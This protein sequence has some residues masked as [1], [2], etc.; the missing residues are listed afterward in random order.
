MHLEERLPPELVDSLWQSWVPAAHLPYPYQRDAFLF[1]PRPH[2]ITEERTILADYEPGIELQHVSVK[3]LDSGFLL[4][5]L[6]WK[7]GSRPTTDLVAFVHVL[8]PEGDIIAQHDGVPMVGFRPTTSWMPDEL[9][10]DSHWIKL[11]V[12][13]NVEEHILSIG[14]YQAETGQRMLLLDHPDG[15]DSYSMFLA[16]NVK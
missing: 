5:N 2:D 12:G 4:V 9:I 6:E 15:M 10:H 3:K 14:L 8:S 16:D 13:R 11:P 1:L 7:A